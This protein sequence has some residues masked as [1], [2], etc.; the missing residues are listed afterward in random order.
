MINVYLHGELGRS[1]GEEW[2][3]DVGSTQEAIAAIDANGGKIYE[4][5]SSRDRLSDE[6]VVLVDDEDI[7]EE[8]LTVKKARKEIHIMPHI[9]GGKK[10]IKF[11]LG[12]TLVVVGFVLGGPIG[13]FLISAGASLVIQGIIELL[14][15]PPKLEESKETQS[16]L[17]DGNVNNAAQGQ[18]VPVA[19]GRLRVGSQVI[20]VNQRHSLKQLI[21]AEEE[22]EYNRLSS[23][24]SL[25][26]DFISTT[27]DSFVSN[28]G[29]SE[30][31]PQFDLELNEFRT[32]Q[33]PDFA[34]T[35]WLN[36]Q[37]YARDLNGNVTDNWESVD[38]DYL[39]SNIPENFDYTQE[40]S[41]RETFNQSVE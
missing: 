18:A 5:L 3:L 22:F 13:G 23:W 12:V 28:N 35:T 1:I 25:V 37:V 33:V 15:K 32:S 26:S 4:F 38:L 40:T 8:D 36:A 39:Y 10:A 19:Y 29:L 24:Q 14:T 6:Y 9:A 34:K 41:Y 30:G 21:T 27:K 31:D 17:Q 7:G 16:Y 20:G 2:C 11:V